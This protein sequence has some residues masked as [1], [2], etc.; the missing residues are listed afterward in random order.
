MITSD[1]ILGLG[2][3]GAGGIVL[4]IA[5]HLIDAGAGCDSGFLGGLKCKPLDLAHVNLGCIGHTVQELAELSQLATV[6]IDKFHVL[7]SGLRLVAGGILLDYLL[8]GLDCIIILAH[9]LVDECRLQEALARFDALGIVLEQCGVGIQRVAVLAQLN[10]G[11]ALLEHRLR[12][13]FAIGIGFDEG[14]HLGDL[15]SILLAQAH[16]DTLLVHRI[17]SARAL[18]QTHGLII[19]CL[20]ARKVACIV[21]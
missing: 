17:I 13:E 16:H 7:G 9:A 4:D 2:D 8:V 6:G 12:S 10:L 11:I 21:L 3:I 20:G 14:V 19:G 18:V 15:I 5:L 1:I